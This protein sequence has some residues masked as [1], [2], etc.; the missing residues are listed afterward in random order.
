[1]ALGDRQSAVI[2][3]AVLIA[4]GALVSGCVGSSTYGTGKTQERQLLEDLNDIIPVGGR[5]KKTRIDYSSRPKLVKPSDPTKLPEPV[6]TTASTNNANFPEDPE[7]RRLRLQGEAVEVEER[8]G[9]VPVSELTRKKEG[10]VYSRHNS[11]RIKN[12][13]I[14]EQNEHSSTLNLSES[15]KQRKERLK[16]KAELAGVQGAAP[17]RYLTEPPREYRTPASTAPAGEVGL[18][19][20][21]KK[22]GHKKKSWLSRINPFD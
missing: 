15:R 10:A 22:A 17:R 8:S 20:D 13:N 16:R 19:E 6:Q 4:A 7:A 12:S 18:D 2:R 14:V 3:I 9:R 21:E 5:E 1:M 11:A